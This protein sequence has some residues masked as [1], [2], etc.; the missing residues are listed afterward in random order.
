MG[1][2]NRR[3]KAW[4]VSAPMNH[5]DLSTLSALCAEP[6]SSYQR[7]AKITRI[8]V[9]SF[10]R[11]MVALANASILLRV[12]ARVNYSSL[13]LQVMPVLA[14]VPFSRVPTVEKAC[15]LH[16]YT[17]YRVRCLGSSNGLFMIFAIP[18]G[19]EFQLTE[20]F[21]GLKK[22]GLVNE[23]RILH[24]IAEPVYRNADF[25]SYDPGSDS[26]GFRTAKWA[27]GL[28]TRQGEL[29]QLASSNLEKLDHRDLSLIRLLTED[30]RK[31]QKLIAKELH[32]PEYHVSRRF[33]FISENRIV[34]SWEVFLGR[35]LFRLAPG[36]L[37][38][39]VCNLS[40]T[41][42]VARGLE[43]LP[44]QASFFPT[45]DGFLLFLGLPTALFTEIGAIMLERSKAVSIMWTD[46]DTSMRYY[47]D[48]T[49][50]V[51]KTG[52][53]NADRAFVTDM[54]LSSLKRELET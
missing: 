7:L 38:E 41:R 4:T 46:Y 51:E 1:D 22:L 8:S 16:P 53:W 17:R 39:A 25:S 2:G 11:R 44:F 29:R 43:T 33:K 40:T 6:L 30:A 21:E 23:Y 50:F 10:K 14:S 42:A 31:P 27:R 24:A 28:D 47:F 35:K 52:Q 45:S 54:P 18:T 20:F 37:F 36:A 15:D 12:G 3:R 32:L 5:L 49:P 19:T 9:Q 13:N 48:E 26:W 34:P